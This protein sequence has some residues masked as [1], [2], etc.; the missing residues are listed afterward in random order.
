MKWEYEKVDENANVH[1]CP[2]CDESGKITGHIIFGLPIWFD[3]HPEE[4]K[5]LG[6]IKHIHPDKPDYDKQRQFLLVGAKA[7]DEYTIEDYYIVKDKS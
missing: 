1:Y 2:G 4:R 7:I 6:W 5:T 3:E